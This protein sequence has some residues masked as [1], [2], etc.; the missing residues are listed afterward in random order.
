MHPESYTFF[1]I[2]YNYSLSLCGEV[3]GG[4][5]HGESKFSDSEF[6]DRRGVYYFYSRGMRFFLWSNFCFRGLE[7]VKCSEFHVHTNFQN[8]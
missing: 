3:V 1:R 6:E 4:G 7:S 8:L 2:D 5:S